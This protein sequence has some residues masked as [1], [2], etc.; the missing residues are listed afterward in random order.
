MNKTIYIADDEQNIRELICSF[1]QSEGFT[2]E[3]FSNG[4]DLLAAFLARPADMVILDIM[5]PGTDG[6]SLCTQ[7]RQKSNVPIIIV[8]ARDSEIDRITGITLGSDDYLTKPFSPMELV[9]RVKALF[10]RLNFS[11]PN[12]EL[13]IVSMGDMEINIGTRKVKC[14][15]KP[16]ELTPTELAL[17]IYL[18]QNS[19]RAISRDELLKNVWKF[20]FEVD[21]RATDDVIKRLRKKLLSAGSNVRVQSVWGFGFKIGVGD[22]NEN[23]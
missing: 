13:E 23:N 7:I 11:R 18:I 2:V 10:R 6:L 5:M 21:T 3:T 19:E 17:M 1:L 8:S 20:D 16:I 22:E 15:N 9:A 14:R 12:A 4:D